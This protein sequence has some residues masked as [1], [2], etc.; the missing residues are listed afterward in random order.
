[1]HVWLNDWMHRQVECHMSCAN[2]YARVSLKSSRRE[3]PIQPSNKADDYAG[4]MKC[5]PFRTQAKS[6]NRV[7]CQ[8]NRLSLMLAYCPMH[9]MS[10]ICFHWFYSFIA[11]PVHIWVYTMYETIWHIRRHWFL[12]YNFQ[13]NSNVARPHHNTRTLVYDA[14]ILSDNIAYHT[15]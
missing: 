12:F 1:M 9:D 8:C 14:W 3:K 7:L 5:C 10:Q 4:K 11:M 2:V 6:Q 15:E 13:Y